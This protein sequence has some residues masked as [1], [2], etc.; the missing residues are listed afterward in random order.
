MKAKVIIGKLLMAFV[1]ISI[2]FAA[3]KE[4]TLR[5]MAKNDNA[6]QVVTSPVSG[7]QKQSQDKVILYYMHA[8]FRCFTCNSIESMAKEVVENDFAEELADGRLEW[9]SVNFQES[10]SL[11]RR[12]GVGTSTLVIVKIVDGEE[13]EFQRM[14]EVWTKVTNPEEFKQYVDEMVRK[15]LEGGSV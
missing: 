6:D 10:I 1:L 4:V 11:G 12:Y 9:Q 7:Q 14:D 15:Y 8:S 5:A 2:G 3:G 13:V